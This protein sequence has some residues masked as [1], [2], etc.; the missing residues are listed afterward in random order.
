MKKISIK[1]PK[2]KTVKLKGIKL[3]PIK[4]AKVSKKL[5]GGSNGSSKGL[6]KPFKRSSK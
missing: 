6:F 5:L 1:I 3:K 2:Q 4:Q